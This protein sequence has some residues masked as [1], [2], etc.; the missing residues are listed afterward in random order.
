MAGD[1]RIEKVWLATSP[2]GKCTAVSSTGPG[3]ERFG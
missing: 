2:M 3:G 1:S